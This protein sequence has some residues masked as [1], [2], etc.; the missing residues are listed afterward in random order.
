MGLGKSLS[1]VSLV[2][3]T[4]GTARKFEIKP[5]KEVHA[6][7][8]SKSSSTSTSTSD[9]EDE[10]ESSSSAVD[11]S[12]FQGAVFG[13][14]DMTAK[15]A[16]QQQ[17][18][19]KRK[20]DR[21]IEAH[22]RRSRI[23]VRSRAT[24]IVCPL[25]TVSNWEDQFMEHW[26]G[27]VTVCA[28]GQG[29]EG[30][31]MKKN[32][33][34]KLSVPK[35]EPDSSDESDS[36]G[37]SSSD[38]DD[39]HV[40]RVYVYHGNARNLD[41][42]YLADFD[43][44]ITTFS[45]LATEFSKQSRTAEGANTSGTST[46][47]NGR[48][49]DDDDSDGVTEVDANG[50]A[51]PSEI[52]IEAKELEK[53][54]NKKR[55]R[56]K[57]AVT[58]LGVPNE[59]EI[60]S[61]LQQIEWFRVVLDEAHFIKDANTV[62]SRAS[63][64][65]EAQRRI[66]LTGTPIQNKLDDLWALIKFIRLEPFDDK[67]VWSEYVSAPAKYGDSI[68]VARL[69]VIMRHIT[70]RRTKETKLA[71]GKTLLD[72]PPRKDEIVYLEFD[73]KE[74][75]IYDKHH[76]QSKA[77]FQN[78]VSE[79]VDG[80]ISNSNY[81]NILQSILRLRQIC[82][83]YLLL[84]DKSAPDDDLDSGELLDYED[85]VAAINVHGINQRRAAAVM[86][87]FKEED[88]C[89]CSECDLDLSCLAAGP[90]P[91]ADDGAA[92]PA[93]KKGR[94]K[95][96]VP[97]AVLTKCQHLYCL[98]CFKSSI[99]AAWPKAIGG[100]GRSCSKCASGLRLA[101]DCVEIIP[102]GSSEAV[103]SSDFAARAKSAKKKQPRSR[104]EDTGELVYSTKI[105]HLIKDLL[106]YSA[107]N[108]HSA[109]FGGNLPSAQAGGPIF[110]G[111]DGA[112]E[113]KIEE[114][115]VSE[116]A[117]EQP[118]PPTTSDHEMDDIKPRVDEVGSGVGDMEREM[119]DVKPSLNG[120][121][122]PSASAA[123]MSA[124]DAFDGASKPA[125]PVDPMSEFAD[126]TGAGEAVEEVD[127]FVDLEEPYAS[128]VRSG[129]PI[130]TIVFSQWTSMLDRIEDALAD[131]GIKYDRLDGT[132]KRDDRT[133]A[134]ERLKKDPT[135]EVLLVSL[136]AGGVGLN[137]TVANR[138]YLIDPFWNPAVENQAVDRIHRLG[139]VRPVIATKYISQLLHLLIASS[140]VPLR[141]MLIFPLAVSLSVAGSME[142]KMLAIQRK[143]EQLASMSLSQTMSKK[144][145]HEQRME[146]LSVS[147]TQSHPVR[148]Y[149]ADTLWPSSSLPQT[150]FS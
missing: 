20:A 121:E 39:S 135:C 147:Q 134:M 16:R 53:A 30:V 140:A 78:M 92:K 132:M 131:T 103:S 21:A 107:L 2:A 99:Y 127:P 145:L 41:C 9:H 115:A 37:S 104:R 70:L 63:C 123:A 76:V 133:R 90:T 29:K 33:R 61:P 3:S 118:L 137:L 59:T 62:A 36:D 10:P 13:M 58:N 89:V 141:S 68:G 46:P 67:S 98:A 24:L 109:N 49:N 35:L 43:V 116:P 69:Q 110:T 77:D 64:Y 38:D 81:V 139:Q 18:D 143:K 126:L 23:K 136:R 87:F 106:A 73:E 32:G 102:P 52:D 105:R 101:T 11:A 34:T 150:L 27:P 31:Q 19:A 6:P 93:V 71:S 83:H 122:S 7:S 146:D 120:A 124:D 119:D 17:S 100:V 72:L 54:T 94:G 65:L 95:K 128:D 28:G 8:K 112:Q 114:L 50:A 47:S 144:E 148:S 117:A 1:I 4:I 26:A 80:K 130:K 44:V 82:D 74:K 91:D 129:K 84:N 138:V 60:T 111:G 113:A 40:L 51:I 79:G 57:G 55:K 5:L 88:M 14:P 142:E 15:T 12:H 97:Q 25:T 75:A 108:P 86:V 149:Q 22:A 125:L 56:G 96:K 42:E 48:T 85:A 45:T 66:C